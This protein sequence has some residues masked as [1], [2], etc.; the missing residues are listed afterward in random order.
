MSYVLGAQKN[1]GE[2]EWSPQLYGFEHAF[3]ILN[4]GD[5]E[6]FRKGEDG[7]GSSYT[8]WDRKSDHFRVRF[9]RVVNE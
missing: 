2:Y 7:Q 3:S 4:S 5:Y 6:F 1:F 9:Y 8:E